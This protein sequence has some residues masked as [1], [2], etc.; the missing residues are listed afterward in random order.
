MKKLFIDARIIKISILIN[1]VINQQANV[2]Y[3]TEQRVEFRRFGV[4]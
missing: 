4:L 2:L 1:F 3:C